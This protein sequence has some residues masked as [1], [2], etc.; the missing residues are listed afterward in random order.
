[1]GAVLAITIH[2]AD[3]VKSIPPIYVRAG[4]NL[5]ARGWRLLTEIL[6]P[7]ALP[8]VLTGAK[9]GWSFAWRSLMAAE[10]IFV[11]LGLGQ[12]L[13]AARELNDIAQVMAVMIVI[14]GL[15]LLVDHLIF[16]RLE[17]RIRRIWG[18]QAG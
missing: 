18:L 15:G 5:G 9:L 6:L 11:S 14:I 8:S 16:G 4:Q 17:R 7:A 10:L 3:G 1:M 13:T 12:L 2:T